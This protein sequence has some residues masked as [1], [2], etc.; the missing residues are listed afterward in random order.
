MPATRTLARADVGGTGSRCPGT[1]VIPAPLTPALPT[2]LFMPVPADGRSASGVT[3]D[4]ARYV[5]PPLVVAPADPGPPVAGAPAPVPPAVEPPG[6]GTR[7]TPA[8]PRAG[9]RSVPPGAA[10]DGAGTWAAVPT[11]SG[12][13]TA[14]EPAAEGVGSGAGGVGSGVAGA[15]R[16]GEGVGSAAAGAG[17]AVA[18]GAADAGSAGVAGTSCSVILV[19]RATLAPGSVP[20]DRQCLCDTVPHPDRKAHP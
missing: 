5:V 6:P 8:L 7:A 16:G 15:G 20:P 13:A 1:L 3:G 19:L 9:G 12:A 4:P 11:G 18:V 2:A 14:A 17:S 10:A